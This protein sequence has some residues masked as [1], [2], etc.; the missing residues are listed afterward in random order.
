MHFKMS[1]LET[2]LQRRGKSGNKANSMEAIVVEKE[3]MVVWIRV[4]MGRSEWI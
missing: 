2:E 3:M 4:V 1:S